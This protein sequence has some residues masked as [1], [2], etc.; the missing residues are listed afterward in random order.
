MLTPI[1]SFLTSVFFVSIALHHSRRL[2][3][4]PL[5]SIP[6]WTSL[7]TVHEFDDLADLWAMGLVVYFMH[8]ISVLYLEQWVLS[9]P[10]NFTAAYNIWS[11]PQLLNTSREVSRAPAPGCSQSRLRFAVFRVAR[12]V[13]YM[14]LLLCSTIYLFPGPF[15]PLTKDDFAPDKQVYSRRLI[16]IS[17][18]VTPTTLRETILRAVLAV[19]WIW[20][21]YLMLN[22]AR[23]ILAVFFICA[24]R[25]DDHADWPVYLFGS[26][27]EAYT[28]RRFWGR[29][30][31]R[32]V[33]RSYGDW[34]RLMAQRLLGC[35]RSMTPTASIT[36]TTTKMPRTAGEKWCVALVVF[37]LSGIL[38]GVVLKWSLGMEADM[39]LLGDLGWYCMNFMAGA[40]ER[41]VILLARRLF[42]LDQWEKEVPRL[43]GLWQGLGF[44]WVFIFFFWGVPKK[45]Y[46]PVHVVLS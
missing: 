25:V 28:L 33:S 39:S 46:G 22:I 11:N 21:S 43:L 38:H 42:R 20:I 29:F 23:D 19:N 12:I 30:W 6:A 27:R 41:G 17:S 35:Q 36:T 31:H 2:W 15:L 8:N 32:L 4:L 18:F 1:L 5:I 24:L 7:T 13:V 9:R 37:L 44:A 16:G 40:V 34:G 45:E 26:L 3:A 14:G 10:Y